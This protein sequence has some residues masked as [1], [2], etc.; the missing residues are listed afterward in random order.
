MQSKCEFETDPSRQSA[1]DGG[2]ESTAESISGIGDGVGERRGRSARVGRQDRAQGVDESLEG[3]RR[4]VVFRRALPREDPHLV[5]HVVAPARPGTIDPDQAGVGQLG[6]QPRDPSR[7]Y[8]VRDQAPH[9]CQGHRP[10]DNP[11][12][13]EDR[14]LV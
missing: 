2:G 12:R 4:I 6:Q 9:E 8:R 1:V 7:R 5:V 3:V 14:C 13:P 11:P 10:I